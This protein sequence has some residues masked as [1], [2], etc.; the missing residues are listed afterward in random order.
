M[1]QIDAEEWR[2]KRLIVAAMILADH[3]ATYTR[4]ERVWDGRQ[5]K[6]VSTTKLTDSA[7]EETAEALLVAEELMRQN[8]RMPVGEVTVTGP[9]G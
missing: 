3:P 5:G 1:N 4:V 6:H 2:D 8:E 9:A 7:R